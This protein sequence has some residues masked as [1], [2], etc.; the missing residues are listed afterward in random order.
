MH[1]NSSLCDNLPASAPRVALTNSQ[2]LLYTPLAVQ[3]PPAQSPCLYPATPF[4]F[5][6]HAPTESLEQHPQFAKPFVLSQSSQYGSHHHDPSGLPRPRPAGSFSSSGSARSV[7]E[8][9]RDSIDGV[10]A[11]QLDEKLRG[12]SL[13]PYAGGGLLAPGQ[14]ISEYE[15]ALTPP[16]PKQALGFKVIKRPDSQYDGP[17]IQDFPNGQYPTSWH[18]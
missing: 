3:R 16:T 10:N 14:R 8:P 13:G 12:L 17:Q 4:G 7:P 15:N 18:E 1:A 5:M 2:F 11:D 9:R 6:Q